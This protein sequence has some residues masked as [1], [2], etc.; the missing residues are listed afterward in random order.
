GAF[1]SG[2]RDENVVAGI[3]SSSEFFPLSGAGSSNSGWLSKVYQALLFRDTVGD[4]GAA[5]FLSFLNANSANA[6]QTQAARNTV[7]L[8]IATSL[9]Y[10]RNLVAALFNRYLQRSKAIPP[11]ASDS[12]VNTFANLMMQGF[13][14]EQIV[15]ILISGP[16]Y[17]GLPHQFP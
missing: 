2:G 8:Q 16:E 14:Q 11:P 17:F 4:S 13:T 10:R 5:A 3:V 1:Q 6:A 12:E 15:G 7:A 9:E